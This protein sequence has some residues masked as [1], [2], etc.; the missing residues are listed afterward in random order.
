M[1]KLEQPPTLD[2]QRVEGF[3]PLLRHAVEA[4]VV[5]HQKVGREVAANDTLK[6][7]V[8]TTPA[9]FPEQEVDTAEN[10]CRTPARRWSPRSSAS[11][12]PD[13]R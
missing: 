1:M 4:E 10:A 11:W 6:T 3:G 12:R 5:Q 7:V 9:K 2:D 13:E 8:G